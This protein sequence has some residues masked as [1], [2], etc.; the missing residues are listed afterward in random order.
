M[1][2]S[3]PRRP[4]LTHFFYAARSKETTDII[5]LNKS[6]TSY[7]NGLLKTCCYRND[8]KTKLN[9]KRFWVVLKI[10][11]LFLQKTII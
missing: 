9:N 6:P 10:Y 7:V 2:K 3:F 1:V 8:K 11:N 5:L 4:P